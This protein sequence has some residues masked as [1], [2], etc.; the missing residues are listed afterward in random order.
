MTEKIS[1]ERLAELIAEEKR[2]AESRADEALEVEWAKDV[3]AA[4]HELAEYRKREAATEY[5]LRQ[6]DGFVFDGY[7]RIDSAER[8]WAPGEILVSRI[9]S[10]SP[11][12]EVTDDE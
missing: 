9:V 1:D 12:V 8:N 11:W 7:F 4:L 2:I 3:L 10:Y 6:S 5:G